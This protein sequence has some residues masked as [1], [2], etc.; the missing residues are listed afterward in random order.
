M[1]TVAIIYIYP[2]NY[3]DRT[4]YF[5]AITQY[6]LQSLVMIKI[7]KSVTKLITTY[8]LKYLA[9]NFIALD[10][11]FDNKAVITKWEH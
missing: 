7:V 9:G 10:A 3:I 2:I 11:R 5:I 1:V 8:T 6:R 4:K